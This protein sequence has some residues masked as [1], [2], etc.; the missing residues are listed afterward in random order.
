DAQLAR[1][2]G[3]L[4]RMTRNLGLAL[5]DRFCLALAMSGKWPVVTTDRKWL[6]M[7]FG[8]EVILAREEN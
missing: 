3:G 7:D 2:A 5:G 6:T 1:I 4:E 8:I